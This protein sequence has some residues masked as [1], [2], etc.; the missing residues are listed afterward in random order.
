MQ[1]TQI[2]AFKFENID[3]KC[4]SQISGLFVVFIDICDV[5]S[6]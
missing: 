4:V 5:V 6:E 3:V 1:I 2:E